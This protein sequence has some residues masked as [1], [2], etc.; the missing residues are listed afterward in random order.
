VPPFLAPH[1]ALDPALAPFPYLL[2]GSD[3]LICVCPIDGESVSASR[4]G[5]GGDGNANEHDS[6][7]GNGLDCALAGTVVGERTEWVT[8]FFWLELGLVEERKSL[9]GLTEVRNGF[10]PLISYRPKHSHVL[11]FRDHITCK[12]TSPL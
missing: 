7:D 12:K 5:V 3:G 9:T 8:A 1:G 2:G 4:H 10:A 11:H 6:G